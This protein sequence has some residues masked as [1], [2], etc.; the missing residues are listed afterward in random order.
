[1]KKCILK[2]DLC[3]LLIDEN[4][5]SYCA[6]YRDN[7]EQLQGEVNSFLLAKVLEIPNVPTPFQIEVCF[8]SFCG[9]LFKATIKSIMNVTE[10]VNLML[11][12]E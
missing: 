4:G 9:I 1:M 6:R 12:Y 2:Q 8:A 11:L 7:S 5:S 3:R 10:C